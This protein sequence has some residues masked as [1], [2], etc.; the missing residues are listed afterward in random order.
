M[1]VN[2]GSP[3]NSLAV[4]RALVERARIPRLTA[5]PWQVPVADCAVTAA[6]YPFTGG[7]EMLGP[8]LHA[9][10]IVQVAA[11]GNNGLDVDKLDCF[12]VC[13]EATH[14][15]PCETAAKTVYVWA[16]N[17]GV[18][19]GDR[20]V[21][22]SL[23]AISADSNYEATRIRNV[24]VTVLDNAAAVQ[25]VETN[26]E[27]IVVEDSRNGIRACGNRRSLGIPRR[28]MALHSNAVRNVNRTLLFKSN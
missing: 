12:I 7:Y 5:C 4:C 28:R 13:W 1:L 20:V 22:A 16:V 2:D 23:S 18:T 21:T 10:G 17:D 19:E 15:A 26:N 24:E 11:A 9:M 6:A 25:I 27:T 8:M 3:D 14:W